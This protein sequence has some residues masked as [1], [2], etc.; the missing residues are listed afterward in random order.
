MCMLRTC[1]SLLQAN[2]DQAEHIISL[3]NSAAAVATCLQASHS[4]AA[5][6]HGLEGAHMPAAAISC[7]SSLA[8]D[9]I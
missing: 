7:S 3:G 5:P 4:R 9:E 2:V 1:Q 6:A 8:A